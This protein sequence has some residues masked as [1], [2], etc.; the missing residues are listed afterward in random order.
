MRVISIEIIVL[1]LATL[2]IL[3]QCETATKTIR[4]HRCQKPKNGQHLCY[5]GKNKL[6]FDRLKGE[7]CVKDKIVR[8]DNQNRYISSARFRK[9]TNYF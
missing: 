6:T 1:F 4:R 8:K 2:T 3:S 5:C 7:K 9:M